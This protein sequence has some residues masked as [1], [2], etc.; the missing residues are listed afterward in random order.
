MTS[1]RL[2]SALCPDLST[3]VS[4]CKKEILIFSISSAVLVVVGRTAGPFGCAAAPAAGAGT[5]AA[6][7]FTLSAAT[8]PG[9]ML[10]LEHIDERSSASEAKDDGDVVVA[11]GVERL[12]V[13]GES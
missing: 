8:W 10:T 2:P 5:C 6:C 3:L 7:N 11:E 4:F 12:R 1:T 9:S 13:L